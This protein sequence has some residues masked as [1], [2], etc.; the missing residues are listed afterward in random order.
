MPQSND[1]KI[2][3]QTFAILGFLN[4]IIHQTCVEI[5]FEPN[6]QK[7]KKMAY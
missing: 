5:S 7:I 3:L 6:I 1:L 2:H 4:Y